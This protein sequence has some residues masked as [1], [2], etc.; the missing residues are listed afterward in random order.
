MRKI[1][2]F[3]L[4]I[5]LLSFIILF[6][7]C[8]DKDTGESGKLIVVATTGQI[9]DTVLN[10][11]VDSIRVHNILGPGINPHSYIPT[12]SD[13]EL[14]SKADLILW[15]GLFLEANL[16]KVLSQM[17]RAY[18]VSDS[19]PKHMLLGWE[20]EEK[21]SDPHI[22][23]NPEIWIYAVR[24]ITDKLIEIDPDNKELYNSNSEKYIKDIEDIDIY[25]QEQINKIPDNIRTVITSHDAFNYYGDRYGI[26]MRA[27]QGISTETEAG[28]RDIAD[29]A[30]L[31]VENEVPA[32]FVETSVSPKLIQALV[33][34]VKSR[35]FSGFKGIGG[36]LYSDALGED[37]TNASTYIGM[38]KHN[39]DTIVKAYTE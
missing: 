7:A 24:Y 21:E 31:I 35:G 8:E 18:K 3:T 17:N 27:I 10:I 20:G 19:I 6:T 4:I 13:M 22:W 37:G 16:T 9:W 15:N 38:L 11:S 33:D 5:L 14:F 25:I 29:L 2:Y 30:E 39:T 32:V 26:D 36:K 23:N 12:E 34:A 1:F 28:T